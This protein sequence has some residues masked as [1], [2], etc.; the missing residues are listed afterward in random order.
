MG[1][2]SEYEPRDSRNVTGQAHTPDGHWSGDR[3]KSGHGNE[4][5]PRDSRNVTGTASTQDG[6][7][8]NRAGLPPRADGTVEEPPMPEEVVGSEVVDREE[9]EPVEFEPDP[10]LIER[11]NRTRH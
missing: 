4:Y 1:G 8:T 3:Q 5:A 7:W 10:E 9:D 11:I 6:R 2:D